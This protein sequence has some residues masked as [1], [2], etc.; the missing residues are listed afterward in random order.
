[1]TCIVGERKWTSGENSHRLLAELKTKAKKLPFVKNHII[2]PKL[3]LKNTPVGTME[4]VLLPEDV[5]K[6]HLWVEFSKYY[7]S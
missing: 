7:L 4:G 5:I 3:F 6:L 1:M 2:I